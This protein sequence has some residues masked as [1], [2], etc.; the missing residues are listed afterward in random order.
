M[1]R[2]PRVP[3]AKFEMTDAVG[4]ARQGSVRWRYTIKDEGA[5]CYAIAVHWHLR[6]PGLI[7]HPDVKG[8]WMR[9][10]LAHEAFHLSFPCVNENLCDEIGLKVS[11]CAE[12]FDVAL[13]RVILELCPWMKPEFALQFAEETAKLIEIPEIKARWHDEEN[14]IQDDSA[15]KM[16]RNRSRNKSRRSG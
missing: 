12:P 11:C 6:N 1:P 13:R 3:S 5:D 16:G 4:N 15:A 10:L 8:R 7:F 9:E 2:R 14:K